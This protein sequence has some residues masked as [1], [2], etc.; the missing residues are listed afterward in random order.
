MVKESVTCA[1]YAS[2][3]EQRRQVTIQQ[4]RSST[5]AA[6]REDP[7]CR[8]AAHQRLEADWDSGG[9]GRAAAVIDPAKII[10]GAELVQRVVEA[11]AARRARRQDLETQRRWLYE[12]ER[13]VRRDLKASAKLP[14][15]VTA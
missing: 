6:Q 10:A 8:L 2:H 12:M 14:L 9:Q 4:R 5:P 1:A 11:E 7:V 15:R 3:H 13:E